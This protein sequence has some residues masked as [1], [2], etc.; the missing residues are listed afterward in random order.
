LTFLAL[1][2][3]LGVAQTGIIT[4]YVGPQLPVNGDWATTP[5]IGKSLSVASDGAGGFYFI[6]QVQSQISQV[7]RVTADGRLSF[8]AGNGTSGFSGDGGPATSAQL[9]SAY[10]IAIDTAGNLFIADTANA[11]IRKVTP[12]GVIS[13]VAGNGTQGYGGDGG[14]ATSAQLSDPLGVA[15]DTAGNLFIA[16]MDN[17]RIRKVTPSGVISTVAGNGTQGYGGDGG[18]ATSAQF[19][20][21]QGVAVDAAGNLFIA[22][23]AN[24]CIRKV[25]PGGLISTVAG[26]GN[27]GYSGD[28]GPATSAQINTPFG[29]AVDAAGNLF[30][31]DSGNGRI[32][33]VTPDGLISTVAGDGTAG[34]S[35]DGGPATSAQF[36][37]LIG[38]AVDAA[39]NLFIADQMNARIRKVTPGGLIS[40]VAGNGTY[41][42]S[43]DGGPATSAQLSDPQ[44]VAVDTA[45]NLF[46]AD[47]GNG[48]IRKVTLAGIISTVAGNGTYGYSGDGGPATSAQFYGLIGIAVDAA[49]NLFIADTYNA[50]IRKVTPDGLISTVAG[51]GNP[52][53]QGDGGPATSARFWWPYGIAVDTVGNLFIADTGNARIRKV[54]PGGLISTVAGNGTQGFEGDGGPALQAQFHYPYGIAVDT[55]GNLFIADMYNARIRKVTPDGMIST[56]AGNGTQGYSGDGGPATS[57]QINYPPS[58]AVDLEGNLFISDQMNSRIRKVTPGGLI[59]TVAGDGNYGYSGDGGPAT[60]ARLTA[61]IGVAVDTAGNLL[62]SDSENQRIRKVMSV[63]ACSSLI[64]GTGGATTCQTVG[65]TETTQVGYARFGVNSGTTPYG[66]AVFSSKQNGVTVS[67]A[68][69]PASPPTTQARVFIDYRTNVNAIPARSNAGAVDVNTGI[70]V[71]NNGSVTANVTY[72]LLDLNGGTLIT[73]HGILAAGNH[74]AKFVDQL[75]DVAPD[76]TM[77]SNFQF[78]SLEIISDQPISV[79]AMRGTTNQRNEFLV[80]T[81]PTA[82][83]TQ[84]LSNSPVYFPQL[85]DGGGDTTSLVLLNTSN[86]TE[87]GTLQILDNNGAPLAVNQAGGLSD[88]TFRYSIASGGGFRFQTDGSPA[89]VNVG[90]VELIPDSLSPTPV[91]FGVFSYNPVNVMVSESGIPATTSTTHARVYVDLSGNHDV[92]LAVANVNAAVANVTINAYQT[93]GATS[94]GTSQG[95]LQLAAGGHNAQF[96][97]QLI[98]GLPAGFTGVLD[99]SSTTPFA[100]VTVRSLT[101]ERGDFLMTT[102]PVADLTQAAPAPIIFPQIADGGGYITEFILI[103][104][105]QAASTTLNYYDENGMPTAY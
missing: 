43:G 76:F 23:T 59:S 60:S 64:L 94:I 42:Y 33:K 100:A 21:P 67:E 103:S 82:D 48:R 80:S 74:F 36:W 12:S 28:G 88:S 84:P 92:G 86:G 26:N 87:T 38:V 37:D 35:G 53:F 79:L 90:W 17:A 72:T 31:A 97:D 83:L 105:G 29:I 2:S 39:G 19:L 69:V 44:G 24:S 101:N 18:P 3:S 20:Y 81:T 5:D 30:I 51:D 91:A 49:G 73:G 27:Y 58:V 54:T 16:D 22:D 41:G 46:I 8:V 50:C 98:S 96:A 85:A 9:S 4:T 45:G 95:P 68:G 99:I 32:R 7:Y 10:G 89:A 40:T 56:V 52:G 57:A 93:D 15:V 75:E 71:E 66:I 55:A 77:P 61:P 47:G 78:G 14:P 25:T 70:A 65:E 34:Y 6:S 63:A 13:T 104:S 1:I 102:F 62:I 11:R